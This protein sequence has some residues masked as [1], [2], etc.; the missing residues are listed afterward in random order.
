M[1]KGI[2][3]GARGGGDLYWEQMEEQWKEG[4][5]GYFQRFRN[6]CC[7][8]SETLIPQIVRFHLLSTFLFEVLDQAALRLASHWGQSAGVHSTL[9]PIK[10]IIKA[11]GSWGTS[12]AQH[13]D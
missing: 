6:G 5:G 12:C 2:R 7:S 11:H 4:K 8:S 9:L 1:V 10:H 13:H 3:R